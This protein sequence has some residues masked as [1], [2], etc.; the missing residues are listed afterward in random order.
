[1]YDVQFLIENSNLPGPRGNLKLLYDFSKNA[2][3]DI[4]DKC[5]EYIKPDVRNSPEEF[6]AMCGVLSF[7]TYNKNNLKKVIPFLKRTANHGSWRVREAVAIAIQ[8]IFSDKVDTALDGLRSLI[9]GNDI[10]RRAVVAGLCEPK[11]LNNEDV[12][13]KILDILL[14]LS[15]PFSHDNKLDEESTALRKA[16]G[17]GWSVVVSKGPE[18]GKIIFEELFELHG[19]HI[20]W[21]IKENLKKN[22]LQKMDPEWVKQCL[23][24]M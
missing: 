1:M 23:L 2:S 18:N 8:E 12:N 6:V 5:L 9:Q 16:L 14:E 3:E 22:R 7:S 17:Y 21:I 10:E 19:K 15:K 24:K 20:N 11:L 4:I 13:K